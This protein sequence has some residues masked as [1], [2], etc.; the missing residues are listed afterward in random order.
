MHLA[1]KFLCTAYMLL[2]HLFMLYICLNAYSLIYIYICLNAYS[3]IAP[4]LSECL[5][6]ECLF[7]VSMLVL[8]LNARALSEYLFSV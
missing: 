1:W 6:S 2:I 4:V 8:R 3:L 7:S 5:L